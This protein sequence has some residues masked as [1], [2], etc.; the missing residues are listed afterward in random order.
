MSNENKE[1]VK[2]EGVDECL[3]ELH[4][5]FASS[6][7]K[8]PNERWGLGM[9]ADTKD[10]YKYMKKRLEEPGTMPDGV[11]VTERDNLELHLVY[12]PPNTFVVDGIKAQSCIH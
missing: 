1:A 7:A 4:A 8:E 11:Q 6:I 3:K 2:L 5:S 10:A 9:R 12:E